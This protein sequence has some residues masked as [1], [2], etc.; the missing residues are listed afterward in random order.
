MSKKTLDMKDL[1]LLHQFKAKISVRF[2]SVYCDEKSCSWQ[3]PEC[4]LFLSL[5]I[6]SFIDPKMWL[7]W[8][9]RT[10]WHS[11]FLMTES[12]RICYQKHCEKFIFAKI[13][14]WRLKSKIIFKIL[15]LIMKRALMPFVSVSHDQEFHWTLKMIF[16]FWILKK[17]Q[18]RI[19]MNLSLK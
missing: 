10:K 8:N 4:H 1:L 16:I 9:L 7:F 19:F 17:E 6:K 5:A 12:K 18:K 15:H 11:E 3:K 2:I 13:S 14:I